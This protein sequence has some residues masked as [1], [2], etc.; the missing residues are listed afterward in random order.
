ML[1]FPIMNQYGN[2]VVYPD[3]IKKLSTGQ[4]NTGLLK[5][6]GDFYIQG[7]NNVGQSGTGN[8]N[9]VVNF[10]KVD[11]GVADISVGYN[12]SF[13]RKG[14]NQ[15]MGTGVFSYIDGTVQKNTWTQINSLFTSLSVSFELFLDIRTSSSGLFVLYNGNYL[16]CRGSNTNGDLGV[17]SNTS[18]WSLSATDVKEVHC[19]YECSY[20]LKTNGD[21]YASGT[22]SRGQLGTGNTTRSNTWILI[23]QNVLQVYA[24]FYNLIIA[25]S[26]GLYGVGARENGLLGD[27][28]TSSTAS[29]QLGFVKLNIPNGS[30]NLGRGFIYSSGNAVLD[31]GVA[32]VSGVNAAVGGA[33]ANN[34]LF[35]QAQG[36]LP[37]NLKGLN[38]M[39][40]GILVHDGTDIWGS[41]NGRLLPGYGSG[42]YTTFVKCTMPTT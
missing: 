36:T 19:G 32:Y 4:N 8:T 33:G 2:E 14:T 21:L 29:N 15:I 9:D 30:Y 37:M 10:T 35:T 20:I 7:L 3:V 42:T 1:P 27:G 40:N 38:L 16:Y 24:G 28:Y 17:T 12:T 13:Y 39:A 22:N 23:Q 5:T 18:T 25:K 41:G 26:D 11:S 34:G 31:T 6:N